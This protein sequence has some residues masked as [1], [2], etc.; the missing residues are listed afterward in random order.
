LSAP[1]ARERPSQARQDLAHP[2]W[3]WVGRLRGAGVP[4]RQ[5]VCD[6]ADPVLCLPWPAAEQ[7]L[8]ARW[9]TLKGEV[10]ASQSACVSPAPAEGGDVL[11]ALWVEAPRGGHAVLGLALTPPSSERTVQTVLLALP[12]LQ[13]AWGHQERVQQVR[14]AQVLDLLAHVASHEHAREAAQDW[15]NRTAALGRERWP[16]A[17]VPALNLSYFHVDGER[18]RWW[19]SSD[20]AWAER[21]SAVLE[22]AEERA[23]EALVSLQ[24]CSAPGAWACPV[25]DAGKTV[26][27]L[28]AQFDDAAPSPP[29]VLDAW[30]VSLA[31]AEPLLRHWHAS[32]RSL[33][34]HAASS[35]KTAWQGG[36]GPGHWRWK[37]G[38]VMAAAGILLLTAWPVDDRV[39]ASTV[40]EG[41]Q[42]RL[43][44]APFDGFVTTVS[45][46][47]G[48]RVQAGQELA[49]LDDR[50]ILQDQAQQRGARDQATARL[51]QALGE[52]DPAAAAQAQSELLQAEAQLQLADTKLAR[53][54]LRAPMGGLVVT[55]D[56]RQKLGSPIEVG[57]EMFEVADTERYR[58]VLHV[59]DRDITRVHPGQTGLIRLT[60]HPSQ[61]FPFRVSRVTAIASVADNVNG[62][63]VEAEWQ[64]PVPPLSPGMQGVGKVVVGQAR[65]IDLW[66]RPTRDWLQLKLWSWW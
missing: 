14:S 3:V 36:V 51:R 10:S 29:E 16:G 40:I 62:F 20:T 39:S 56:W 42:R 24:A 27:V 53:V 35:V 30:Q 65:L 12:W 54:V 8:L 28:V 45:V 31:L 4:V 44:T 1:A 60:G 15:L 57:K 43:V 11:L 19:V 46:R 23:A 61:S 50:D 52:H 5:V 48:E 32:E 7:G 26:G 34:R 66:T 2:C 25:L 55:G 13:Q 33:W 17:K 49:R 9:D 41:Q 59:P 58:V 47:P 38:A 37:L 64:G 63:R 21:G 22:A 6:S 18:L